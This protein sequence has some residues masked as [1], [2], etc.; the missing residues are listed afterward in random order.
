MELRHLRYFVT[1]AE[2]LHFRRAAER[3]HMSQPP[4]SLQIRALEAEL[5]VAL[6]DRDRRGVS[7]TD[8]GRA[9]LPEARA[10][11]R[12]AEH[13]A[14]TARR[15]ASGEQGALSVG[16]VGSTMYGRVPEL[17]RR[18]RD[19]RPDVQIRLR[20]LRPAEQMEALRARDIDI[21]FLRPPLNADGVTVHMLFEEAMVLALPAGHR[22][23]ERRRI[24]VRDLRDESIITLAA[25]DAPGVA[26]AIETLLADAAVTPHVVQEA[27]ELPTA[28]GLVAAGFGVSFVPESLTSLQRPGVVYRPLTGRA[29]KARFA[30]AHR[31]G[32]EAPLVQAFVAL[33]RGG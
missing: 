23:A 5:S 22:L 30:I 2:E 20:E 14:L 24:D 19:E 25:G 17:L 3:L 33:A 21:G 4:L 8:A 12:S 29:R 1:V 31:A 32:D 13:A 26:A 28:V 7:L 9:F 11:L 27:T 10:V 6:L 15:V 16:F 18:F